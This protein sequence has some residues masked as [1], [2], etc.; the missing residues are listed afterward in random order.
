MEDEHAHVGPCVP[1]RERLP[2]R[3]DAEHGIRGARVV[4]GD[5]DDLHLCLALTARIDA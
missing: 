1:G 5:D 2:V 4:L 3:P